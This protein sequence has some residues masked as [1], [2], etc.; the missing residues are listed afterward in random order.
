MPVTVTELVWPVLMLGQLVFSRAG[1]KVRAG[2]D[3]AERGVADRSPLY[4]TFLR[5]HR[6]PIDR[7]LGW[8][9]NS[10]WATD[11]RRDYRISDTTCLLNVD[12][13]GD[14]DA[15]D[16]ADGDL[17]PLLTGPER[18]AL[19]RHRSLLRTPGN[20]AALEKRNMG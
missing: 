12:V 15:N 11:F 6:P 9:H 18:R 8:G 10:Q 20:R 2:I 14:I 1:V 4:W 5:R 3:H 17:M 7:S 13:R 16:P 19:V